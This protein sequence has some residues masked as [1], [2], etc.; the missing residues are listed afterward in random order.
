M[1][2]LSLLIIAL[3]ISIVANAQWELINVNVA[4]GTAKRTQIEIAADGTVYVSYQ[5]YAGGSYELRVKKY[6]GNAWTEITSEPLAQGSYINSLRISEDGTLYILFVDKEISSGN[7]TGKASCMKYM[8]DTN[9]EYV[10]ERGFSPADI[11]MPDLCFDSEGNPFAGFKERDADYNGGLY[12]VSVMKFNGTNWEFIGERGIISCWSGCALRLDNNDVPYIASAEGTSNDINYLR[13]FKY[14][15]TEWE[16]PAPGPQSQQTVF[17]LNIRFNSQNIPHVAFTEFDNQG[18]TDDELTVKF[19]TG[20]AW[21]K[22][23]APV[24]EGVGYYPKIEFDNQDKLYISFQDYSYGPAPAGVKVWD[25]NTWEYVGTLLGTV[26]NRA[27]YIDL[28]LDQNQQPWISYSNVFSS[29]LVSVYQYV[30]PITTYTV[31]FNIADGLEPKITL[32][33]FVP[34]I[35]T[36]GTATFTNVPETPAPGIP[37]T[38]ELDGYEDISDN[39]IVDGDELV[40]INLTLVNILENQNN[41]ITIY[42]NPSNGI[43]TIDNI[44]SYVITDV[45]GRIIKKLDLVNEVSNITVDISNYPKGLYFIKNATQSGFYTQKLVIQ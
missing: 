5:K 1:N 12:G 27:E 31:Y 4:N 16:E 6:D 41:Q 3:T 39:I 10:G 26:N 28:A 29:Y 33:G 22:L 19:W 44:K 14:N 32:E 13:I 21:V 43:F 40:N 25:G 11:N 24:M 42:P 45:N 15:G 18:G 2:K 17:G 35:A 37:Y 30:N 36:G 23:G 20:T 38:I 34:Q 8:G 7:G 9:W